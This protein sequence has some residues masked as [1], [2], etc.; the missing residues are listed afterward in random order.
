MPHLSLI[1]MAQEI[2][3]KKKHDAE[4]RLTAMFHPVTESYAV[5][6]L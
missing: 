3:L 4:V 5:R 1:S 2:Q 6:V